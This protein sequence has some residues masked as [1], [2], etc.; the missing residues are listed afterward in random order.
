MLGKTAAATTIAPGKMFPG[1]YYDSE[2]GLHY[3]YFRYYDPSTGRYVTSDP[4]GLGG[5]LNTYAYVGGNP[6]IRFDF[7]G[8]SWTCSCKA[9]GPGSNMSTV[10]G[11]YPNA[12]LCPYSCNCSCDGS[13]QSKNLSTSAITRH[14]STSHF[15]SGSLICFGQVSVKDR[16]YSDPNL[17]RSEYFNFIVNSANYLNFDGPDGLPGLGTYLNNSM[18]SCESCEKN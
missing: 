1:Q 14:F 5:G 16:R 2:S 18:Q 8:L 6:I 13:R 12:K 15:D 17:F 3:N 9:S 10:G 11:E 7:M 4:I